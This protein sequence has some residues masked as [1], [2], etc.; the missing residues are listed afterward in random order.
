MS[1]SLRLNSRLLDR[2]G[3]GFFSE[4]RGAGF[5]HERD[6]VQGPGGRGLFPDFQSAT[7]RRG[8]R[9]GGG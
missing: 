9:V 6:W 2:W 3:R 4:V 5:G 1:G 7:E 8:E